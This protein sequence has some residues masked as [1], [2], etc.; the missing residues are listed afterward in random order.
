M[1]FMIALLIFVIVIFIYYDFT[2]NLDEGEEDIIDDFILEGKLISSALVGSGYPNDWNKSNV[3]I[4]GLTNG[5]QRLDENKIQMFS[6]MSY[7]EM[8]QIFR[9]TQEFYV[10]F[11]YQNGTRINFYNKNGFGKEPNEQLDILSTT[12]I[13]IYNS[14]LI[15]MVV[16]VWH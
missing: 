13:V 15:D 8:K 6:N 12:R 7:V 10:Y 1:D 16:Q 3:E 2:F 14:T 11:S 9:T 4:I 5:N